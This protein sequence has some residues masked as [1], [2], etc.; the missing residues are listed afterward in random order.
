MRILVIAST[1]PSSDDDPV[2]D[3]VKQQVIAL[4]RQNPALMFT[5][6][7]PHDRRSRTRRFTKHAA[8][9][10]YRFH[11]VWPF[12]MEKLAGRGI[13][14][15]LKA[16][17][18]NYLLVPFLF[19]GEFVSLFRLTR[20]LK[21]DLLY[22]HWFTPQAINARWVGAVTKTPFV[23]TTHA[24]DV[25]V[26]HKIPFI[27]TRIVRG[28]VR[29]A[30][31]FTAVSRRSMAKLERFFLPDE[32]RTLSKRGEII[33]MG[34]NLPDIT[35]HQPTASTKTIL[36]MGRL[37]EKKGVR[38]LLDAFKNI[39][40]E[41]PD[42]R[43]VI[44]GD[45][46]LKSSLERH[47][48]TIGVSAQVSFV[49]YVTGAKKEVLLKDAY[50]YAVPSIITTSGDAEGLPVSLMEGLAHGKVCVATN[51]SGADD[52]LTVGKDGFLVPQKD[53]AALADALRKSLSLSAQNYR[54][55]SKSSQ[56]TAEQ[57]SWPAVATRHDSFL[58]KDIP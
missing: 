7:A 11:Y 35:V 23:F 3:F 6:L 45:G 31:A 22:A 5:V 58:F 42:A 48:E 30:Q 39:A 33:P 17:A 25:D 8:Y 36:F 10:E 55:I 20:R 37:A 19:V 40:Y 47:A 34:V 26:W 41:Y 52:I 24:S 13:M 27:G 50:L 15:A 49:G 12:A 28:N 2:P 16:N 18:F 51:E 4:K 14:P 56:A 29:K 32:W 38:Y 1:F 57:F 53:T 21:P 44:A 9:D 54:M 46:P 43:L